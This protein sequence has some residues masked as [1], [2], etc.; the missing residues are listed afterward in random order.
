MLAEELATEAPPV[1]VPR[2]P[3]TLF[4]PLTD[5]V[6]CASFIVAVPS[7]IPTIPPVPSSP[8]VSIFP[9]K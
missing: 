6:A 8:V 3:P 4:P 7:T 5:P 9:L 1:T 2:I